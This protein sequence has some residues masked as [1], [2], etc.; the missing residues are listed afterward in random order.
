MNFEQGTG[1]LFPHTHASTNHYEKDVIK[2]W[3]H[4][5]DVLKWLYVKYV[6]NGGIVVVT[7]TCHSGQCRVVAAIVTK[8]IFRSHLTW[9]NE[10][11]KHE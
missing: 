3:D 11:T 7:E 1:Q 9:M 6:E 4:C 5:K 8:A 10:H 2:D